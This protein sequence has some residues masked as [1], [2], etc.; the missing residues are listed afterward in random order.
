MAWG[1]ALVTGASEGI[2]EA[3]ARELAA[4]DVELVVVARREDRLRALADELPVE[5]EVLAADLVDDDELARVEARLRDGGRPVDLLVNNAGGASQ[6][7]PFRD[8]D[9]AVLTR[10]AYLN[11]LTV[12]RLTHAAAQAM[13]ARDGGDVINVSAGIGFYPLPGAAAYG[14][15]KAFVNSL[16]E[17]LAY[18]LR[19][20]GVRVSA[21][22]PGFTHTGAQERL[23]LQADRIPRALWREPE[24]VARLALRAAERGRPLASPGAVGALNAFMGRHLPRRLLVP[25][26]ARAQAKFAAF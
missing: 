6:H 26:V 9:H 7:R 18:E 3:F 11:T 25:R 1:R 12:L 4:R 22:C 19:G 8:L 5:V 23:G 2:G 13:A 14:A 21:V 17:A 15:S 10:D 20:S 16:T 24:Q